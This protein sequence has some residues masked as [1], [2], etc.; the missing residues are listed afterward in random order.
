[1][2]SYSY[3][4]LIRAHKMLVQAYQNTNS[5]NQLLHSEE[6]S[7]TGRASLF[8]AQGAMRPPT[9]EKSNILLI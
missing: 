1:M 7:P 8:K 6:A 3:I 9:I 4:N 2:Q 5:T